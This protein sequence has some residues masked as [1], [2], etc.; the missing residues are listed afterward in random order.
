MVALGVKAISSIASVLILVAII[1]S[2]LILSTN[3]SQITQWFLSANTTSI[4]SDIAVVRDN[5]R[6]LF[7]IQVTIIAILIS[8]SLA[9]V[10]LAA[11]TYSLRLFHSFS[12]SPSRWVVI[13][14]Y[15][16]SIVFDFSLLT[17]LPQSA[18]GYETHIG[19]AYVLAAF[20]LPLLVL[21]WRSMTEIVSPEAIIRK[22]AKRF[23]HSSSIFQPIEDIVCIS[24]TK[25]DYETAR[26]GMQQ[27]NNQ[28][29]EVAKSHNVQP[30]WDR[31][32]PRGSRPHME[33]AR[34]A[35]TFQFTVRGY[36]EHVERLG[37]LFTRKDAEELALQVIDDLRRVGLALAEAE[38]PSNLILDF[39]LVDSGQDM[40]DETGAHVKERSIMKAMKTVGFEAAEKRMYDV[41]E[42]AI[43][44]MSDVALSIKYEIVETTDVSAMHMVRSINEVCDKAIEQWSIDILSPIVKNLGALGL[45]YAKKGFSFATSDAT[46]S[47]FKNT[48]K[49]LVDNDYLGSQTDYFLKHTVS[50]QLV[51]IGKESHRKKL[52]QGL[53]KAAT[54]LWDIGL[55]ASIRDLERTMEDCAKGLAELTTLNKAAVEESLKIVKASIKD[56]DSHP[57]FI[58][59]WQMYLRKLGESDEQNVRKRQ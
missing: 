28:V 27:M 9:A 44:S 10:E 17:F 5:L 16:I 29:L 15:L 45:F 19:F 38:Y 48:V 22:F 8:L 37:K 4:F 39:F 42:N 55:W 24:L 20:N 32:I 7:Q 13:G 31:K 47:L 57:S 14:L 25:Y 41:V 30:L 2:L 35:E 12:S 56:A 33:A 40:R 3:S 51:E 11:S 36:C 18:A 58:K 6:M 1:V 23:P 54:G 52:A 53:D 50:T 49:V 43:G 26:I 46:R 59:L 21:Y 34:F